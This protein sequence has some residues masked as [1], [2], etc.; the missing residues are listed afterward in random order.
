M[1]SEAVVIRRTGAPADD[2]K[3]QQF[4]RRL[5]GVLVARSYVM[6]DYDCRVEHLERAVAL[7]PGLSRRPSPRAAP[8]GL[9]RRPLHGRRQG[10]PADHGRPVRARRPRHPHHGH[11]RLPPLSRPH[12][13]REDPDVRAQARTPH[14]A[15]HLPAHPHPGGPAERGP[16]DVPRHHR[17]R[18]DAGA[19]QPGER[20][21]FVFVAALF[22]GVLALLS[23]PKVA[24]DDTGVTVVNLTRTR[25]LAWEEI[26]RVNLRS[27]DPWVFLDLSDGTSLP[28]LGIQPGLASSRPSVTPAPCAP[29]PR[30][31]APATLPPAAEHLPCTGPSCL[32]WWAAAPRAPLPAL[33]HGP[34][35]P[36]GFFL[37]PK[38]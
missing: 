8:R 12:L 14:P 34:T 5:Q 33:H 16:G 32:L 1:K 6:M 38:E 10:G 13:P 24:A 7:T 31:A 2:P 29:S 36:A 19:A 28:A 26:L 35:G 11:P 25:R 27:G 21:S 30:R 37:R 3:V 23:R 17:H 15:G 20:A 4:L 9:G 18:D 22:F